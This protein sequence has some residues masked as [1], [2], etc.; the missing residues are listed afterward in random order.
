MTGFNLST[1][2]YADRKISLGAY[3]ST[4]TLVFVFT[5]YNV[6]S[7]L[8]SMRS[9]E[10]LLNQVD[11][12][13]KEISLLEVDLSKKQT[14]LS[15]IDSV[16]EAINVAKEVDNLNA[17]LQK[18]SFSWSEFFYSLEKVTPKGVSIESINPNYNAKKVNIKGAALNLKDI[19]SFVDSLKN[20]AY[21]KN[22]FLVSEQE[23]L[24]KEKKLVLSFVIAADGDF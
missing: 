1:Y 8:E 11:S 20:S 3:L 17:I 4:L 22:A 12:I 7:Y 16:K 15:K 10:G 19:T 14:G 9:K 18:Q 13:R 21:I 2:S 6:S 23:S 5:L 24:N